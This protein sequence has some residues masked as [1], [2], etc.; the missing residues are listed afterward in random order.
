MASPDDQQAM[1][2]VERD[3]QAR[4]AGQP[5]DFDSNLAISNIYRAA[6]AVRRGAEQGVLSESGLTW[7]GFTIMWVLW[8]WGAMPTAKL[9]R[10]CDLAKGTLTGMLTTL[11]KRDLVTRS[12]S[13]TDGRLVIVQP[14]ASGIALIDELFPRF[15]DFEIQ[16][17]SGLTV[18]ETRELARLLRI[19]IKNATT[20]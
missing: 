3:V 12:K 18:D 1:L 15:N 16:M 9:A 4:L 11:E 17:A 13:E 5:I 20:G 10:E 6:A 7:G 14:T 8:V 2:D 19:V